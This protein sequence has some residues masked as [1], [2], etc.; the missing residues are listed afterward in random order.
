MELVGLLRG[1]KVLEGLSEREFEQLARIAKVET[2]PA[3]DRIAAEKSLA[4][5]IYLILDGRVEIR[6]SGPNDRPVTIDILGPGEPFGWSAL[7][8]SHFFTAAIWVVDDAKLVSLSGPA[9]RSLF[10]DN[11]H[12]GYRFLRGMFGVVAK[13]V[14]ALHA[15]LAANGS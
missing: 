6:M 1:F 10:D 13:R 14:Q 11:N 8:D 15:K 9:L 4:N 12:V 5:T 7:I 3:G 2:R